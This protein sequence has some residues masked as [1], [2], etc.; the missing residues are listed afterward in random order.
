[1]VK[2]PTIWLLVSFFDLSGGALFFNLN[3]SYSHI[4]LYAVALV[5]LHSSAFRLCHFQNISF[6]L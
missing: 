5:G 4:I 3:I 6:G 1:M 2:R